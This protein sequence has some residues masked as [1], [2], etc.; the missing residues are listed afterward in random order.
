MNNH[1]RQI[2][3]AKRKFAKPWEINSND[4]EN[5]VNIVLSKRLAKNQFGRPI[6]EKYVQEN[7]YF[8][9]VYEFDQTGLKQ[10]VLERLV[11]RATDFFCD[12]VEVLH[13]TSQIQ[14]DDFPGI[15]NRQLVTTHILR[16]RRSHIATLRKQKDNYVCSICGLKF[17]DKYGPMGSN[18]AEAHHKVP[19]SSSDKVRLTKIKDL[20]TVCANC[21]RMLHRMKGKQTDIHHLK[22]L[23]RKYKN[24]KSVD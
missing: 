22:N 23:V 2:E 18:F 21:H 15:E 6:L 19:L 4:I 24:R 16:E 12:I 7:Q 8:Y 14:N 5:E 20:I 10:D 17:M 3:L 9:G 1:S 13:K 11:L